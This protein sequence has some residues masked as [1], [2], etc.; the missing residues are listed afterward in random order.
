MMRRSA[1][2]LLSL[3]TLACR[4]DAPGRTEGPRIVPS[5]PPA[6]G[7]SDVGA[8]EPAA[9]FP[10]PNAAPWW[11]RLDP[12]KVYLV[13]SLS[14]GF[15]GCEVLADFDHLDP[16]VAGFPEYASSIRIRPTDGRL[17]Y[18]DPDSGIRIFEA[19]SWA[20][21]A[22]P[23][24]VAH[25]RCG[26]LQYPL[27]ATQNDGRVATPACPDPS[28]ISGFWIRPTNGKI[29]Y[30][31]TYPGVA[32][33]QIQ[34]EGGATMT[35]P[36]NPSKILAFDGE[37]NA[38]FVADYGRLAIFQAATGTVVPT[39][40]ESML[41]RYTAVRPLAEGF[42]VVIDRQPGTYS[43]D[44]HPGQLFF[45]SPAGDLRRVADFPPTRH[46]PDGHVANVDWTSLALD[47]DGVLY[48]RA[49]LQERGIVLRYAPGATEDVIVFSEGT[50]P[51]TPLSFTA[52][53]PLAT[54]R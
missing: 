31:C 33:A 5:A 20:D 9:S 39:A 34:I 14:R 45:L 8:T 42:W 29:L 37:R 10:P 44:P 15:A 41:I 3:L 50:P 13:A 52:M 6:A 46:D 36:T 49:T 40:T 53:A 17:L 16:V 2:L 23:G 7:S 32:P 43:R 24:V 22:A 4:R 1:A 12:K 25:G 26:H 18:L 47:G 27:A 48:A 19:D 38:L 35:I 54:A 21:E 30:T 28:K 51:R 11:P